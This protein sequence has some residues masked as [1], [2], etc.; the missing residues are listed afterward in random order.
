MLSYLLQSFITSTK[1]NKINRSLYM[2]GSES[3]FG[4]YR[5]MQHIFTDY[6]ISKILNINYVSKEPIHEEFSFIPFHDIKSYMCDDI[7]VKVDRA[8]MSKSLETRA[9]FLDHNIVN[10]S[11]S[12]PA[13][14]KIKGTNQKAIL[15][16]LLGKYMPKNFFN[17]PKQGFSVPLEIWLRSSLKSWCYQIIEKAEK[18]NTLELNYKYIWKM[19]DI[20]QSHKSDLSSKLWAIILLLQFELNIDS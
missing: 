5:R 20:H 18:E 7:L 9:P 8:S 12:L 3:I 11:F 15:K 14:M 19:W 4:M 17:R 10:F 2:L 13:D 6:E 16:N 1:I